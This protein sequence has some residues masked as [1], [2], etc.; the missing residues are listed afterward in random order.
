MSLSTGNGTGAFARSLRSSTTRAWT[1]RLLRLG[2]GGFAS[3]SAMSSPG[4]RRNGACGVRH[5]IRARA[6]TS[7][8]VLGASQVKAPSDKAPKRPKKGPFRRQPNGNPGER[9][10][11]PETRKKGTREGR[12][13]RP[14]GASWA[15]ALRLG[16]KSVPP[17][18]LRRS[19]RHPIRPQNGPKKGRFDA[20]RTETRLSAFPPRK[21]EKTAL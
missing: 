6:K 19:K 2:S 17:C 12:A 4:N 21:R 1:T 5:L 9:L 14:A 11:T 20:S 8:C 15:L 18:A 7:R 3:P 16:D 13:Q 10:S